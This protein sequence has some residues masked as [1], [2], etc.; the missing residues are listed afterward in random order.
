MSAAVFNEG[1]RRSLNTFIAVAR[2][3]GQQ[4]QFTFVGHEVGAAPRPVKVKIR[5]GG[6]RIEQHGHTDLFAKRYRRIDRIQTDF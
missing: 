5:A 2:H 3:T 4:R 1:A 6:S